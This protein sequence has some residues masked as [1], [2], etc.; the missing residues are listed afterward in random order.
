MSIEGKVKRQLFGVA[1]A[2]VMIGFAPF[3]V[4]DAFTYHE[5]TTGNFKCCGFVSESLF[6]RPVTYFMVD[7]WTKPAWTENAI[8][9]E[10]WLVS[11][12]M[13]NGEMKFWRILER[14]PIQQLEPAIGSE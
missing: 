5:V 12:G 11:N 7:E 3:A 2:A 14:A 13:V 9:T 6:K 1:L 4:E 8:K 10:R